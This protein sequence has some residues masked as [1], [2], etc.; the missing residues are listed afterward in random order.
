M[1]LPPEQGPI[2]PF[3][4]PIPLAGGAPLPPPGYAAPPPGATIPP[5]PSYAAP[6]PGATIPP[7]PGYAAPPPSGYPPYGGG[8]PA[9]GYAPPGAGNPATKH[10]WQGTT[11]MW[12]GV[13]SIIFNCFIPVVWIVALVFGIMGVSS[14]KKGTATNKGQAIAGIVLS[15]V[16]LLVF[17]GL[18]AAAIASGDTS[19]S[20]DY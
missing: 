18:I 4:A 6:P 12:V 14:A 5:P 11:A 15:I 7:P 10:N 9:Y 19:S 20:Y 8:Q 17:A 2:D 3:T 16:S 1:S 13:G